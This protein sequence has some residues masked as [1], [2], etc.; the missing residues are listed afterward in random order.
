MFL[1]VSHVIDRAGLTNEQVSHTT[2][3]L[4]LSSNTFF[5]VE[6]T[7]ADNG[8]NTKKKKNSPLTHEPGIERWTLHLALGLRS[9]ER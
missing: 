2:C 4:G 3:A 5:L 7:M 6:L 8:G 9:E 1:G